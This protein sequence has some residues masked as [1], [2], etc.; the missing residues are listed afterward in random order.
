[1]ATHK[2]TTMTENR[3]EIMNIYD[4]EIKMSQSLI[5]KRI[6]QV[7]LGRRQRYAKLGGKGDPQ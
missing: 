4:D 5:K 3:K 2:N 7:D 6:Q 1:M